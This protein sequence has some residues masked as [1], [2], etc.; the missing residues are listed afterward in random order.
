MAM[1]EDTLNFAIKLATAPARGDT[2][3]EPADTRGEWDDANDGG[4]FEIDV[5]SFAF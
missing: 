2:R 4:R 5:D 1:D 3:D